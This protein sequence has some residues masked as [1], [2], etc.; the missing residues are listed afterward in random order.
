MAEN[1]D[2][3]YYPQ[4]SGVTGRL[5]VFF[6]YRDAPGWRGLSADELLLLLLY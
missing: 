2:I 4:K 3:E 5:I 6:C 1:K